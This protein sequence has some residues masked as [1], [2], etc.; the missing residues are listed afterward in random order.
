VWFHLPAAI[1][2]LQTGPSRVV[3]RFVGTESKLRHGGIEN[4]VLDV[5]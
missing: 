1:P 5:L 4:V 3:V 2:G